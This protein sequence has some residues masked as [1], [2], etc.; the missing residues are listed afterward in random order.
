MLNA[1]G[2]IGQS[3]AV[4]N[5]RLRDT[6]DGHSGITDAGR[7]ALNYSCPKNV[8]P[9]Y[10]SPRDPYTPANIKKWSSIVTF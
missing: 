8:P 7:A 6:L 1:N 2:F 5:R 9:I 4:V 10:T 3:D